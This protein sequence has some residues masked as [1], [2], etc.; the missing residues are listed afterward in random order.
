METP[1]YKIVI[2]QIGRERV[3]SSKIFDVGCARFAESKVMNEMGATVIGVDI[4]KRQEPPLGIRFIE[5]DF[6]EWQPGEP[7][8]ILYMSQVALFMPT[9]KVIEKIKTFAP[10]IIALR[11][12]SAYPE[13]NWPAEILKPLWFTTPNI[14][15]DAFEA[16]GYETIH[17]ALYEVDTPDMQGTQRKFHM[18]EYIGMAK[19]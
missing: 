13:P 7:I 2:E 10:K 17:T 18:T 1:F 14:W 16:A 11:T 15:T 3:A 5:S 8:D 9:E 12:M 4:C 6:L 19:Q